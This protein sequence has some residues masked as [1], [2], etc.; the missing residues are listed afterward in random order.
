M[1]SYTPEKRLEVNAEINA[2]SRIAYDL[3][4]GSDAF[5]ALPKE[6]RLHHRET[7]KR[8]Y[9]VGLTAARAEVLGDLVKEGFV[10]II[11]NPSFP[12]YIKIGCAMNIDK[13]VD[14]FNTGDPHRAYRVEH[15]IFSSHREK[16]E[17]YCHARLAPFRGHGEWFRCSIAQARC[18]LNVVAEAAA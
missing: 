17:Q 14:G 2:V 6:T 18:I 3:V 5:Y 15:R 9:S 12:G 8:L 11:T 16:A 7:A 4:G 10:Y 13:R 1:Q